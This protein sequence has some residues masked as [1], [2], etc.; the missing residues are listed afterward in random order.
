MKLR[1]IKFISLFSILFTILFSFTL[2]SYAKSNVYEI[3]SFFTFTSDMN[4][5]EGF[6]KIESYIL[7][8]NGK[9]STAP[10]TFT[11]LKMHDNQYSYK[12]TFYDN[13]NYSI[14][15]YIK[16]IDSKYGTYVEAESDNVDYQVLVA[17][18]LKS[19]ATLNDCLEEAWK[20]RWVN[21]IDPTWNS[22]N[23]GTLTHLE[24]PYTTGAGDAKTLISSRRYGCMSKFRFEEI[25]INSTEK[26]KPVESDKYTYLGL[27]HLDSGTLKVTRF[28]SEIAPIGEKLV[29]KKGDVL[30][31]KRRAYQKKVAIAPFDG[32]FSAH[33]MVLRPKTEVIDSAFFPLFIS[34]DYFLDAAIKISV[35]SLSPTINWKDLKNLEF[36]L[37]NLET[38]RKLAKVLWSL[39]D[40]IENYKVLL[41]K[42]D[43]L[44]KSQFIARFNIKAT[45]TNGWDLLP[46]N[47]VLEHP[48]SGEWGTEDLDGTGIKV[49]RTTN[50][51]DYG[52]LDLSDITTR[53][54]EYSKV[55][56][57]ILKL[58]DILIEKSG[59]SDTKP[60][61]RVVRITQDDESYLFNNFTALLRVK[62]RR[63]DP[64]YVFDFMFTCYKMG[65]TIK[66]ENKTTGIH[67]LKL[68]DY[69]LETL[70]PIPSVD[71]QRDY[72]RF[73]EQSDKSKFLIIFL[74]NEIKRRMKKCQVLMKIIQ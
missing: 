31:G 22:P 33:G 21:R 1:I 38:Q 25:A 36:E 11:Y 64:R 47:D 43:E 68:D 34:S 6:K 12:G 19:G 4:I 41:T 27:E 59:G 28:G 14:I 16:I 74:L 49:I 35:G 17:T 26:K 18:S 37:P 29:M 72:I 13:E 45:K 67:N 15:A 66:Y 10:F 23:T 73:A 65:G 71:V 52:V 46:L 32:I 5:D 54:I 56:K 48:I 40:T 30:F 61:G 3:T 57:K 8:K 62:D 42:T 50:F 53:N 69:L 24:T 55:Q 39:I 63:L 7:L 44:V 9:P 51:T 60:V 2:S 20:S 70:I 58:N